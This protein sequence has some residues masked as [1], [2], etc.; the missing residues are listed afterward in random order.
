MEAT[1]PLTSLIPFYPILAHYPSPGHD[2]CVHIVYILLHFKVLF[3]VT[4]CECSN[5][6]CNE[7]LYRFCDVF[8]LTEACHDTCSL[9]EVIVF[10]NIHLGFCGLL[11]S[12]MLE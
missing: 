4:A 9:I 7:L 11:V 3:I 2:W 6:Q 12:W 5:E 1:C 8:Q 10:S